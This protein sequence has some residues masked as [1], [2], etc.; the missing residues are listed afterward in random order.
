MASLT[1]IPGT[2]GFAGKFMLFVAVLEK[3]NLYFWLAIIAVINSA[4]SAFYYFKIVK[5]MFL[6]KS[7]EDNPVEVTVSPFAAILLILL[8][9]PTI[10]LGLYWQPLYDFALASVRMIS[11]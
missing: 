7:T 11:M 1:G 6:K 8:T 10:V 4:I 5:M 2:V 3:G 9:I